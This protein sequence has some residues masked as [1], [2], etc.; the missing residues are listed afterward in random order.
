MKQEFKDCYQNLFK[1]GL[2][3]FKNI[4][5]VKLK[6]IKSCSSKAFST[7]FMSKIQQQAKYLDHS[8]ASSDDKDTKVR[9][10]KAV[11]DID[12]VTIQEVEKIQIIEC[13]DYKTKVKR[14]DS[15]SESQEILSY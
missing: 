11:Y 12:V 14:E 8:Q 9:R 7:N 6:S 4:Q 2:K 3:H 10:E 15:E 1:D 13:G 5:H